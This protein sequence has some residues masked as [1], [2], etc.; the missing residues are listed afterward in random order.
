VHI[1]KIIGLALAAALASVTVTG[2][3]EPTPAELTVVT[4]D[5]VVFT[6]ELLAEFKAETGITVKQLKAGDTGELTNKLIL[7]KDA[8]IGDMVYGID[9]TF[10]SRAVDAE[11]FENYYDYGD[12]TLADISYGDVCFNYDKAWFAEKGLAAPTRIA[13]L[14]EEKYRGLTVVSNPNTSSPG[15]AFLLTTIERFGEGGWQQYWQSLRA[16]DLKVAASWEDAYFTEFSGS[17]GKGPY[18]I[19]LSYSSSPAF[20]I[21]DNGESG[22]ASILDGCFRQIESAGILRGGKNESG[23]RKFIEFMLGESFQAALPTSMYVYPIRL[24]VVLPKE[25]AT[26]ATVSPNPVT[27]LKLDID[28]SREK[29]LTQWSEILG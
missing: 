22:T 6:D 11:I 1:K 16:N 10:A 19:V 4:H 2:C 5:S 8:P 15:L 7:T 9:N 3:S 28:G 12:G 21:R 14:T 29:W 27:G 20:E 24:D 23:A 17:S 18:P 26:W 13:Q 25:W